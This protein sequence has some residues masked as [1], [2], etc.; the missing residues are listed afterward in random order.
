MP[1]KIMGKSAINFAHSEALEE[2]RLGSAHIANWRDN[3]FALVHDL[4][5][6]TLLQRLKEDALGFYP[7]PGT[8]AA[9]HFNNCNSQHSLRHLPTLSLAPHTNTQHPSHHTRHSVS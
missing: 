2:R 1:E 8:E 6:D 5:P 4:L 9:T 3:G 7:A